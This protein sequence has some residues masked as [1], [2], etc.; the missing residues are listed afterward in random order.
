MEVISAM[1][2]EEFDKVC[3]LGAEALV[4]LN[5]EL[6]RRGID[7]KHIGNALLVALAAVYKNGEV[8][9]KDIV[10]RMELIGKLWVKGPDG[11]FTLRQFDRSATK[12][13][14]SGN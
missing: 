8:T 10:E 13:P 4:G 14:A 9:P 1:D 5:D 6:I 12:D 11:S 7:P 3:K 2:P